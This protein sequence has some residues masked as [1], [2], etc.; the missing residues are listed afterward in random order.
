M[1]NL[2]NLLTLLALLGMLYACKKDLPAK[3]EN[4]DELFSPSYTAP[5][6]NEIPC[7]NNLEPNKLITSVA[8]SGVYETNVDFTIESNYAYYRTVSIYFTNNTMIEISLDEGDSDY[9]GLRTYTVTTDNDPWTD[10][11]SIRFYSDL[12][13]NN[14]FTPAQDG[15]IYVDYQ[16][17]QWTISFCDLLLDQYYTDEI[18][19]SA[20]II[21]DRTK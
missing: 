11:A 8:F 20:Q 12:Y 2:T 16:E 4:Y 9:I 19:F 5:L 6:P 13:Y 3:Q 14:I 7:I 10:P 17:T 1:R 15:T 21:H 18:S